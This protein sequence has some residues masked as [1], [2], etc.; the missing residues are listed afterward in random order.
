MA[1]IAEDF[2]ARDGLRTR[3]S[4]TVTHDTIPMTHIATASHSH[5]FEL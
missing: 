5:L 2:V 4:R 3:T 1:G